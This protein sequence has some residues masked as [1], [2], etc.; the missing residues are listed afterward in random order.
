MK[1]VTKVLCIVVLFCAFFSPFSLKAE[2]TTIDD[3][4]STKQHQS[5]C[6]SSG[7]T[8]YTF[9][10]L[11]LQCNHNKLLINGN[12][13]SW[14]GFGIDPGPSGQNGAPIFLNNSTKIGLKISG[15][16]TGMKLELYDHSY[17]KY[18]LW[19]NLSSNQQPLELDIP[20]GIQGS[21][22]ISKIQFVF[23]PGNANIQLS[24]IYLKR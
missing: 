20:N 6:F 11:N 15:A 16:A 13:N 10:G 14:S 18:E 24:G 22:S 12:S 1:S 23:S 19:I 4:G 5:V 21:N 7:R 9:G 8:W 2:T 3:F 17:K